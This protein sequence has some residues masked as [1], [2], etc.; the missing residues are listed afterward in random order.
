MGYCGARGLRS[1]ATVLLRKR[2]R[3]IDRIQRRQFPLPRK[4]PRKSNS[5]CSWW[6]FNFIVD[7][8]GAA[9]FS[10]GAHHFGGTE[11]GFAG[12]WDTVVLYQ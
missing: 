3:D 7:F 2:R 8:G 11:D 12:Q 9:T 5:R 1:T 6:I 4:R 10:S